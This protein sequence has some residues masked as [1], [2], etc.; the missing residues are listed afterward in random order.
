MFFKTSAAFPGCFFFVFK[1]SG[2][3]LNFWFLRVL[4]TSSNK[5]EVRRQIYRQTSVTGKNMGKQH[6]IVTWSDNT[7]N[8]YPDNMLYARDGYE[9]GKKVTMQVQNMMR[10]EKIEFIC[11]MWT[12]IY[13]ISWFDCKFI[14]AS[15]A[16]FWFE[17]A[18]LNLDRYT[19]NYRETGLLWLFDRFSRGFW[20]YG[21]SRGIKEIQWNFWGLIKNE[22]GFP[23]VT[24][25]NKYRI[26]TGVFVF[27]LGISQ[28][29]NTILWN[30]WALF[31]LEFSGVK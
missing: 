13:N 20:E 14:L 29:S 18:Y 5:L 4:L 12:F 24:K 7:I 2:Y 28:R 21:I 30:S 8:A 10:E 1:F 23:R 25:K 19:A 3:F 15:S 9:V 16:I 11:G 22:V 17:I 26:S 6:I 27:G 31:C